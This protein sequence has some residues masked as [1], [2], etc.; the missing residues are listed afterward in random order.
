MNRALA[1]AATL[2]LL[3]GLTACGEVITTT[4]DAVGQTGTLLV[5]ADSAT[6]HGPVGDAIREEFASGVRTLPQPEPAFSIQRQD[7]TETFFP[8]I[9]RQ[10]SVL[11]A[12]VY[13]NQTST[14]RFLRA[15][16]DSAGVQAL[17]RG[18]RGVFLRPDLWAR[19]QM[20]VYATAP[21]EE[22]LIQQIRA[23]GDEMRTG[24]N[25]INRRRLTRD[26]FSRARQHEVEEQMMERH[27]FAVGV[28]HDYVMVRD[29]TYA[30]ETGA[31]GTFIRMRRLAGSDSWRDLFIYYEDDPRLTRLNPD[32][33]IV[34]RDRLTRRFIRGADDTSFVRIDLRNP[35][36]RPVATDTVNLNG[37]FALE[38]RGTWRLTYEDGAAVGMAGP[39]VSYA[40]YDEDSGRFY[41][42][43]G[44]VFAPAYDKR[45][46]LRQ[47]EAIAYTFRT[48]E[49]EPA[50]LGDRLPD[51]AL[52][53][54]P[55][56]PT[57]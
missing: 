41:L 38:T 57:E 7:L 45:E 31:A 55:P 35:D 8:Q 48:R 29:T 44:M 6:W 25:A 28:Q 27:G 17:E 49:H 40:F 12:G 51:E 11:F 24:F 20:V 19:D 18:G 37:R 21:T 14:G 23:H 52:A 33:V 39:F 3:L 32:S 43:D 13:T 56:P 46:F 16:L 42:I 10:H 34:L 53:E 15:R 4:Q 1:A 50:V 5:V 22:A 54:P 26:M 47:M 30:T 9:R 2:A 36:L